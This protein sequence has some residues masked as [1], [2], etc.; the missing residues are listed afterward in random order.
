WWR[1]MTK[2]RW[3]LLAVCL[4]AVVALDELWSR[5][6]ALIASPPPRWL[7]RLGL[8]MPAGIGLRIANLFGFRFEVE[9]WDEMGPF[10]LITAA[11]GWLVW[12]AALFGLIILVRRIRRLNDGRAAA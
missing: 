1:D 12:T 4:V 5:L 11:I 7:G 6:Y 3:K 2:M 10:V 9:R 8:W